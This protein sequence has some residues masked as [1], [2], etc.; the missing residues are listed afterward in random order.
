[1]KAHV[2]KFDP[3]EGGRYRIVLTY[4]EANH[5][6]QGKASEHVDVVV[7]R[8]LELL[9]SERIVQSVAFVSQD[10]AFAGEMKM[11]WLLAPTPEGTKVTIRC[12]DV[13]AG[14]RQEDHEVGFRSTL[15]NLAAFAEKEVRV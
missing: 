3:R 6:A 4:E 10:P 5:T 11:T 14:I 1:M 12:E 15:D 9:P 7:G 2:E 13:P 8:F